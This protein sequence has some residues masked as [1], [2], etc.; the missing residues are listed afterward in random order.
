MTR[1]ETVKLKGKIDEIDKSILRLLQEDSN[2]QLK[3]I[4]YRLNK[5]MATISDR[6]KRLSRLGV[7]IGSHA[8]LNRKLLNLGTMGYIN[9]N[10]DGTSEKEMSGFVSEVTKLPGVCECLKLVGKYNTRLKIVTSDVTEIS[11]IHRL[12]ANLENVS[13]ADLQLVAEDIIVDKGINF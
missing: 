11:R 7:I 12:V 3:Q 4:A 10:L 5:S 1:T 13:N 6:I 8:V 9:L 2:M